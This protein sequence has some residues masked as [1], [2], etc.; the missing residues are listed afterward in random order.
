MKI[1]S[2][3]VKLKNLK[4]INIQVPLERAC[5]LVENKAKENC[6]SKTGYLR[7]SIT[8]EINNN[9]GIIGTNVEYAPYVEFGTGLFATEGNGRQTPWKYQTADGQWFTTKGQHPQPFLGPALENNKNEILQIFKD[10]IREEL[11]N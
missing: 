7:R 6:P 10:A 8:H 2:L 1:N 9:E 3:E 11:K 4:K 5:L